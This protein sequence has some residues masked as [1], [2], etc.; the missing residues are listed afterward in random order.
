[1][2]KKIA[3]GILAFTGICLLSVLW[4]KKGAD[5][6]TQPASENI[7]SPVEHKASPSTPPAPSISS[8]ET[9]S[10]SSSSEQFIPVFESS[11]LTDE[12]FTRMYGKSYKEDCTIPREDLRYLTVT[13]YGFDG[14][15]HTGELVVN[16][17]IAEEVLAIFQELYDVQY[18]IEKM[19]LIDDYDADDER[20]MAD[21]NSSAFNFRTIS[22]TS[23]LSNHSRGLAI[24]I[25]PLYNPYVHSNTGVQAC[26]PANAAA[27]T[28]RS[29]AFDH[30]IHTEDPCYKI[31]TAHGF[32]WG[33]NWTHSKDYQH[34]E[35]TE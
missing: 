9:S 17:L 22:G 34:F 21:N 29:A 15:P 33:G 2:K 24:D 3:A 1:M 20:S 19:R 31:F 18:P 35:L 26:E 25:N 32:S 30:K 13:H 28:D 23:K 14:K 4:L 11:E 27:Y 12:I 8:L 6:K 5:C 16:A 10:L 7:P